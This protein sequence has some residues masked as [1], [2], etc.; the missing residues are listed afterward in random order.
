MFDSTQHARVGQEFREQRLLERR[1][2]QRD[3][4]LADQRQLLVA[5]GS[6]R[7]PGERAAFELGLA[8]AAQ[9]M[10]VDGVEHDQ[11]A[12]RERAHRVDVLD[13]DV[14]PRHHHDVELAAALGQEIG[15]RADE[16]MKQ[17]LDAALLQ[18]RNVRLPVLE[19]VGDE[20]HL[21]AERRQDLEDRQHAHRAGVVVGRQHAGVDDQHAQL[22]RAI[23]LEFGIDAVG[24]V[25]RQARRP[26]FRRTS[27]G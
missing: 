9:E 12:R 1:D 4:G 7:R 23:A 16:R 2:D 5:L 8:L 27:P 15:D 6:R 18:L 3:V 21:A 17:H 19:V 22:G 24:A 14:V 25:G 10:Q 20:R 26:I 13:R 11:R